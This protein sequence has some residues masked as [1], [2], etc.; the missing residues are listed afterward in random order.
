M[1]K[2]DDQEDTEEQSTD[3]ESSVINAARKR[4]ATD[5]AELK[6]LRAFKEDAEEAAELAVNLA[7]EGFVNTL[8][9]PGLKEDVIG[10][11][12]G[13]PT[14]ESVTEALQDRGIIKDEATETSAVPPVTETPA[15]PDTTSKLSQDV[16]D[17]ATGG[18]VKDVDERLL[19]ATSTDE[20]NQIMGELDAVRDYS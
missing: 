3:G 17:A 18:G 5:K 4:E 20:L 8:G 10:W 15:Q 6:E 13:V 12:E 7:A 14:L 2:S 1:A 16:A 19:A 11:V 9:F